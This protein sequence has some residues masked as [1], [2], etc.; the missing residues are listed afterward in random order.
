M[1][2][3]RFS[4]TKRSNFIRG[5][6][7]DNISI[8]PSISVPA[9]LLLPSNPIPIQLAKTAHIKT[10]PPYLAVLSLIKSSNTHTSSPLSDGSIPSFASLGTARTEAPAAV[11]DPT[12][13]PPLEYL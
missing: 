4:N 1:Y 10:I 3:S 5:S 8:R 9:M 12:T 6:H 7:R 11:F 13:P 2:I